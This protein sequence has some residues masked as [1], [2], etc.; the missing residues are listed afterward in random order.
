VSG[1]AG[2][3][4]EAVISTQHREGFQNE[5]SL[6]FQTSKIFGDTTLRVDYVAAW[7]SFCSWELFH[8]LIITNLAIKNIHFWFRRQGIWCELRE[9]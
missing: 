3:K 2:R 9:L 7:R 8:F 5:Y 6:P 1:K 4:R